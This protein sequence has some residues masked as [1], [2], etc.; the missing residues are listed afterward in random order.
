MEDDSSDLEEER[1]FR[2]VKNDALE[3]KEEKIIIEVIFRVYDN[4]T[5]CLKF[6]NPKSVID[7]VRTV[8]DFLSEEIDDAYWEMIEEKSHKMRNDIKNEIRDVKEGV[9]EI[10][11]FNGVVFVA[12]NELRLRGDLLSDFLVLKDLDITEG[13]MIIEL[14]KEVG[15]YCGTA[16]EIK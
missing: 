12:E 9:S 8:E 1:T 16:V 7:T 4:H 15:I 2:F 10:K 5:H 6:E 13:K 11:N 14:E 3:D